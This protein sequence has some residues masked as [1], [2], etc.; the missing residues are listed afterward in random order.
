MK[1]YPA[2]LLAVALVPPL[3]AG[4][5]KTEGGNVPPAQNK[6]G[7]VD[8]KP[9]PTLGFKVAGTKATAKNNVIDVSVTPGSPN[10][11]LAQW[12]EELLKKNKGKQKLQIN[13]YDGPINKDSLIA[14][15]E[16]GKL[17]DP[18]RPKRVLV[19]PKLK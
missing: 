4:C 15:F 3:V 17:F 1:N 19:Q 9:T 13:F 2:V 18:Q 10:A 12:C 7:N 16:N 11:N 14:R 5:P 6:T 8:V